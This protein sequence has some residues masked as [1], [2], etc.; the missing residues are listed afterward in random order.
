MENTIDKSIVEHALLYK[1]ILHTSMEGFWLADAEG[2]ILEV[3]ESYCQMSGYT[4]DE[5][6]TMRVPDLEA[7]ESAAEVA[8]HM[9]KIMLEKRVRFESKHRRKNGEIFDVEVSVQYQ[10]IDGGRFICFQRDISERKLDTK[11]QAVI[12]HREQI[13]S[14][15]R[16]QILKLNSPSD[17]SDHLNHSWT[18]QLK[19]I[20]L[21]IYRISLQIK[22]PRLEYFILYWHMD[23]SS[24]KLMINQEYPISLGPWVGE[25]WKTGQPI[26][27]NRERLSQLNF[28]SE[29]V[30]SIVEIPLPG[31]LGSMGVSTESVS[32]FTNEHIQTLQIFADLVAIAIKR[33]SDIEALRESEN[34]HRALFEQAPDGIIIMSTDGKNMTVNQAFAQMHGY[35]PEEMSN[36]SLE[37]LDTPETFKLAPERL[38]KLI[39]GE[40]LEFEVEHYHKDG[41]KIPISVSCNVV[42][43]ND[44]PY[45]LGFHHNITN[46][47]KLQI[48][49]EQQHMQAMEADRLKSLGEIATGIA[50]EINQPLNGIRTFAEGTLFGIQRNWIKSAEETSEPLK[51]II[52]QV[53]RITE[54]IDHMRIFG[55]DDGKRPATEFQAKEVIA[56]A[57]KLMG[58]QLRAQGIEIKQDLKEGLSLCY[59]WPNQIEQVI[60]NLISNARDAFSEKNTGKKIYKPVL[61]I[62]WRADLDNKL[63]YLEVSDNGSGIEEAILSKIF[64]PF[65]TTKPVGKGTGLGLSVS[66]G[67]VEKHRGYIKVN[68]QPDEGTTFTIVLPIYERK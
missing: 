13:M 39:A 55:R 49:I 28:N 40:K 41:H 50:H 22:S 18:E 10:S 36:M 43:I 5:L 65:Y 30:Q 44:K 58:A 23:N 25:A 54:I 35:T 38:Q 53:D 33:L 26:I 4:S 59:G 21:P 17:F 56:S 57:L 7:A 20:G 29:Q 60:L 61:T 32:G 64:D 46:R 63:I 52:E 3:N 31:E 27:V 45:F 6:L 24:G 1:T 12:I 11:K 68:S 16:D 8:E 67:I 51:E 62:G 37:K 48:Q 2:R 19:N 42:Q 47:K 66:K 34:Y 14:Q 15:I 9:K